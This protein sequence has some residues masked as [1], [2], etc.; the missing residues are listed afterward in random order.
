MCVC[1]IMLYS[2]NYN[3]STLLVPVHTASAFH[4]R[5]S[6]KSFF[7]LNTNMVFD[8]TILDTEN[9]YD[10]STGVYTVNIPGIYVFTWSVAVRED[11][12]NCQ[13]SL[14]VNG[15]DFGRMFTGK[16]RP[17]SNEMSN[18]HTDVIQVKHRDMVYIYQHSSPKC[19]VYHDSKVE[20]S[21]SGWLLN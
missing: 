11:G 13:T 19:Y 4:V 12:Y 6:R 17:D 8:V 21:F 15:V 2:K 16:N 9:A 3:L 20:S 14:M 18:S 7:R 10:T 5:M 1:L